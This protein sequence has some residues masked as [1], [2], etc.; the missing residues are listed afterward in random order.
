[1]RPAGGRTG[2]EGARREY[3]LD[4]RTLADLLYAENDY[5]HAAISYRTTEADL[6]LT[7]TPAAPLLIAVKA[8]DQLQG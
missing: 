5:I 4:L 1:M 8:R 6:L 2:I 3:A 7:K